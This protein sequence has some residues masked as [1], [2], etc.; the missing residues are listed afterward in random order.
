[1]MKRLDIAIVG[2]GVSG[3]AAAIALAR[4]G[5]R[6]TVYESFDRAKPI[7]SGLML[8]PTGLA[9]LARLS[10]RSTIEELGHRIGRLHGVTGRGCPIF[11]VAYADLAPDLYAV[12]VHRAA[13][14]QSLW[15]A[16]VTTGSRFETTA[17]ITTLEPKSDGR[18]SPTDDRG[19]VYAPADLAIDASG[20]RSGLRRIVTTAE[21]RPFAFGAVWANVP[22]LGLAPGTLAQRYV[23]ARVM[24]GHLPI[25]RLSAK[26]APLVAFSGV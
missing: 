19:R 24:V 18:I 2:A 21:P 6:V 9:A 17:R 11:D 4:A 8:Q 14:H 22:D 23:A 12:G 26:E 1:M 25:G 20:A 10:L 16:F 15:N 5:H 7:G 3:L 13:L